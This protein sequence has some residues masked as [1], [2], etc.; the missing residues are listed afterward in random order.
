MNISDEKP[1]T[2]FIGDVHGCPHE[3]REMIKILKPTAFDRVILLGDL[4]SRGPDSVSVVRFVFEAG[5]ESLMGNHEYDY[6]VN[7]KEL[8][9]YKKLH[10]KLGSELHQW[11]ASRP[12]FIEES[13]FIAVH[14]GMEP[15]RPLAETSSSI[16][17]NIRTWDGKGIDLENQNNPPWY[18]FYNGEKPVFYGHWARRELTIRQNTVGLDSGCVY[19]KKLSAYILESRTIIQIDARQRYYIPPS[20]RRHASVSLTAQLG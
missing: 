5:F 13:N 2:I 4:I 12:L 6:L 16:L 11:I 20:M 9:H 15:N 19:G 8:V 3:L 18:T 7:Y 14:A 10:E 17:L 1:R